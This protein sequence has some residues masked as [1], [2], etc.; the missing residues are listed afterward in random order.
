MTR[1]TVAAAVA[2]AV[3][4]IAGALPWQAAVLLP[5]LAVPAAVLLL[6]AGIIATAVIG[7]LAARRSAQQ[8]GRDR[9]LLHPGAEVV[10]GG[11]LRRRQG[12]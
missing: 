5:L 3:L 4:V 6:A 2:A 11:D 8:P 7:R 12:T 10:Q 1:F 9:A